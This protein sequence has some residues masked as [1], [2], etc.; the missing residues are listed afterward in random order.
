MESAVEKVAVELISI[1][2][3]RFSQLNN[4][5]SMSICLSFIKWWHV[6][7]YGRPGTMIIM[8]LMTRLN[9][10]FLS[11][12]PLILVYLAYKFSPISFIMNGED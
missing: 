8:C 11:A 9:I 3:F 5:P 10:V 1:V 6:G 7:L 12:Q 4:F 2:L